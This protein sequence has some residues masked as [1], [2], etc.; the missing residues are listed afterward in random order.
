[1]G[2]EPDGQ[3]VRHTA[4]QTDRQAGRQTDGQNHSH[5][6]AQTHRPSRLCAFAHEPASEDVAFTA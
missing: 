2:G 5:T 1:M 6:D 4:R 3:T